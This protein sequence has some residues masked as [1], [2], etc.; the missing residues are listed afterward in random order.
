M[1]CHPHPFD[2][3]RA[4]SNPRIGVRGRLSPFKGEGMCWLVFR[5]TVDFSIKGGEMCWLVFRLTVVFS[6]KGGGVIQ[7]IGLTILAG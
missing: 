3:L 2:K 1:V 5:L 4:G 7:D 6:I